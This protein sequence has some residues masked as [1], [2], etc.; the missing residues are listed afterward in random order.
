[1]ATYAEKDF[2]SNNY[3]VNRPRYP[4][5]L[6]NALFEYHQGPKNLALDAGSGP[7]TASFPL[8]DHGVEKVIA[9]DAS[10]VMIKPGVESITPDLK[11]KI[12]F[13]VFPAEN[14][15]EPLEGQTADLVIVAEALHWIN[16]DEFFEQASKALRPNGTL[17]YWGYVEPRFIDFP[18]ANEIYQKYVYEDDRY[19][20][21]KWIQPSK[22]FLRYFFN[23]VHVPNECFKDIE[24]HDYYPG[25]TKT[26]TAYFHGDSKYTMKK[27]IDYLQS[28]S[29]Y[30]TWQKDNV[31]KGED[32]AILFTNELKETFGWTD[33]T[34][35]RVEWGTTYTFA[36]RK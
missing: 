17:A 15:I 11:D 5:S 22:N 13:K 28:W 19:M 18:K 21:P 32:I 29:A 31:D 6:F 34:E 24:K 7:G 9:T 10:D 33:E 35:L 25:E 3:N 1:M 30:H 2:D 23:D 26:H 4:N 14:L 36:R 8:L 16:H 12:E 27:F 20:G